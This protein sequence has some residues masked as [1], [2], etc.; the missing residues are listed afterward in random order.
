LTCVSGRPWGPVE[1]LGGDNPE[2]VLARLDGKF[3]LA[4]VDD[5]RLLLAT[6]LLGA[7]QLYYRTFDDSVFFS[8]HLGL[9]LAISEGPK[10]LN[11]VGVASLL[12]AQGFLMAE[13]HVQ[14]HMRLRAGRVLSCGFDA[15]S[16]GLDVAER[17]YLDTA[18]AL[19]EGEPA[20]RDV[21]HLDELMQ[22]AVA[23]E[24]Y[25]ETDAIMLSGGRDSQAIAMCMNRPGQPAITYGSR[26]SSDRVWARQF[27]RA[28]R[29]RQEV[30][31]YEDWGYHTYA[32]FIVGTDAGLIGLQTA[33][34]LVG[35]DWCSGRFRSGIVGFLG[36][37]LTGGHLGG[38]EAIADEQFLG[39][40]L[41]NR[42]PWDIELGRRFPGELRALEEWIGAQRQA[43][44]GL[45]PSQ[46]HRILDFTTR[47]S[48]WISAMFSACS[49][50]LPLSYPFLY[51]PLM[52]AFFK[53]DFAKLRHQALYDEWL[54][55]KRQMANIRYRKSNLGL[56]LAA[57]PSRLLKGEWPPDRTYWKDVHRRSQD[58]LDSRTPCRIAALDE[59]TALSMDKARAP[60]TNDFP[61]FVYS[62][63]L[64]EA[65]LR[66][67]ITD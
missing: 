43:L 6:D 38:D 5:E 21:E 11:S 14:E 44:T 22:A 4:I 66:F 33:Q 51:R 52:Q 42:S 23:R 31:P 26:W 45:S 20:I 37:A 56:S 63:A 34:N 1:E 28:A 40:L 7:G 64:S 15:D 25:D 27:A 3:S 60:G 46:A 9:L 2:A 32:D 12:I 57:I 49:W 55:R 47:Q 53:A 58:W 67:G 36:D 16:R 17:I 24:G 35:F 39:V 50:F 61:T 13:T 59:I 54:D 48:T 65:V 30:V 18:H 10:R 19:S 29:L 62:L 8:D 41:P